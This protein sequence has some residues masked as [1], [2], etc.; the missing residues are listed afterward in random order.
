MQVD[1]F[2]AL[3]EQKIFP[4]QINEFTYREYGLSFYLF[5]LNTIKAVERQSLIDLLEFDPVT[6]QYLLSYRLP[7]HP[8]PLHHQTAQM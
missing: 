1:C 6:A 2:I 7:P 3:W 8:N 4:P 5:I